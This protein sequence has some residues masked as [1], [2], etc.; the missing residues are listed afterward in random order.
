MYFPFLD[1]LY[2]DRI[3]LD[4]ITP[5]LTDERSED[6]YKLLVSTRIAYHKRMMQG[7]TPLMVNVL[8]ARLK[9]KSI[10]LYVNEINALHEEKDLHK[11]F[12]ILDHLN[13]QELYYLAVMGESELYTSSF[14]SGIYPRMI[15]R[16]KHPDADSLLSAVGEDYFKKFIKIAAI[17]NKLDDF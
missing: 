14:V 7:D 5:L 8:T 2:H 12:M 1:D 3:T 17:Y 11:R 4:S 16:M 15:Q 9:S 6:Y 13:A 10:E